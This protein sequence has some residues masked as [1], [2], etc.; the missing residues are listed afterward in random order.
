MTLQRTRDGATRS[1][2]VRGRLLDIEILPSPEGTARVRCE[3]SF[4]QTG[5]VRPTEILH[6][7]LGL[8]EDNV[9]AARIVRTGL[10][11]RVRE[12]TLRSP[13]EAV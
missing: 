12:D 11:E 1:L 2:E 3:L 5:L 9:H 6:F 4:D 7:G 8:S 13:L 10:F